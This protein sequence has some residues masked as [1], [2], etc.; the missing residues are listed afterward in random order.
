[1]AIKYHFYVKKSWSTSWWTLPPT[2]LNEDNET[3]KKTIIDKYLKDNTTMTEH[4]YNFKI[5]KGSLQLKKWLHHESN[6]M[7]TNYWW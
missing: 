2:E 4:Q 1:M 7:S 5:F 3:E 6:W